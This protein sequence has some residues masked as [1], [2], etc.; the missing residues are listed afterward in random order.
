M[1]I[2]FRHCKSSNDIMRQQ[3]QIQ[4]GRTGRI[5]A[6]F[7]LGGVLWLTVFAS[8]FAIWQQRADRAQAAQTDAA[9]AEEQPAETQRTASVKLS[10]PARKLP[11][12][13]FPESMGETITQDDFAGQPWVASF[14]FT[15]CV[16]SCP[17]ITLEVKKLHDRVA[18]AAPDVRFATFTVDPKYDTVDILREYSESFS[19]DRSRWK[20][21][22]GE[23]EELY[24]LIVN[25][26]GQYVSENVGESR[27]P[28][29][30][31]AHSNRVVLV[32]AEG[33]PVG[34]F[35]AT[36]PEDMVKLRRILTGQDDFPEPGPAL[37]FSTS[38]GSV[39]PIQLQAQPA[40][41]GASDEQSMDDAQ[42]DSNEDATELSDSADDGGPQLT[43]A[44]SDDSQDTL[45]T[46]EYN[47]RIEDQL[48]A[49]AKRLPAT[50]AMLNATATVLLFLGWIAIRNKNQKQHRN[51]MITAFITSVVF[52]G[53]Y[54][55][56]HYALGRYT[57]EHGRRFP[58]SGA[59]A[60]VY[61]AILWPHIIL[62]V[63]V[64]FLAIRVFMHAFAERWDAHKAL[65]KITFPIWMF[66]S[67]T[68]VIIYGMLYHWPN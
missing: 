40:E 45:S 12:F 48:P 8:L 33:F 3:T 22:T 9:D 65:A 21:I 60:T 44:A 43:A 32:N 4:C 68:G 30:E 18:E 42:P 11:D 25:G 64:P 49:W 17:A 13:E 67:V 27:R 26:F 5:K 59:A 38:D 37:Q 31:V 55:V 61:Y 14:V 56:Y 39:L 47:Q 63:F 29:Y 10:F 57:G 28:G 34:T 51:L 54:L 1:K 19:P 24:K 2:R 50:N 53:C 66:V 46:A 16:T 23:Q 6:T 41:D 52:L 58:G 15:R 7:L 36:R 62:A 35:L 20:F